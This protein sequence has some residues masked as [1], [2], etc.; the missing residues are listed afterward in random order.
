MKKV[1]PEESKLKRLFFAAFFFVLLSVC[2][3]AHKDEGAFPLTVHITAVNV[4]QGQHGVHGS[5]STDS[6]GNYSSSVS[7][8]GSYTWKLYT[9]QIEGDKKTYGLSTAGMHYKGGK[10]LAI[11][12][13]GWS[14][15]ATARPNHWLRIGDY[16]GR[17]N[18]D[19]TLEIQFADEKGKLTHQTFRIE[20]EE[21]TPIPPAPPAEQAAK[22]EQLKACLELAKDNPSVTCK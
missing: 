18:N 3:F 7:G 5:G 10:G 22:N 13:M 11:A 12:T 9:A 4:E 15:V 16:H 17:W 14:A 19:G 8:G 1:T 6:N 20:S 2:A 21:I